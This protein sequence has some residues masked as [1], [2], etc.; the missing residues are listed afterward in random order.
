MSAHDRETKTAPARPLDA[1]DLELL[2]YVITKAIEHAAW[3]KRKG[4]R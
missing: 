1:A 2:D 3:R 4:S